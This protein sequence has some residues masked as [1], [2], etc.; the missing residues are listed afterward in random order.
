MNIYPLS[1]PVGSCIILY[2]WARLI[3]PAVSPRGFM[4]KLTAF[5]L[6]ASLAAALAGLAGLAAE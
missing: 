6:A 5:L 4:M 3:L 2:I 1:Q